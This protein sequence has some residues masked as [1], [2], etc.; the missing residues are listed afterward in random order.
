VSILNL[1]TPPETSS[2][3]RRPYQAEGLEALDWHLQHKDTTPCLVVPTGGGKSIM[4]A[5]AIQDWKRLYP[6]F[7]VCILA[8]RKELVQQNA[9]ELGA[10]WP[11]GDIGIYSA[12]LRKRDIDC[13][14]T[15]AHI[16]S[17]YEK[18]GEF[19]PFDCIIVDEAHRIPATGDG[20]YRSF[21]NGC[22][23]QNE[24][25]C[26]VG[27]TATPFRMG[28]G[29]ICHK[30]HILQE[31]C[32]EANVGTLIEQGFLC[33]LRSKIG[34]VQ[35][36]M[37]NVKRNSGGDYIVKSLANAV[38][39]PEVVEKAVR[40]AVAVI[41]A[42]NR[43][44]T[45]FFCVDLKHCKDVQNE[46]AKYG[47]HAPRVTGKT[48]AA[49]RDMIVEQFK[50]GVISAICNVNVYTEGFNAKRV[51][52]IVLLRP[53]LSP[54]LYI[55]MVGRGLRLHPEKTDCLVLDYAHCI[56]E[57][58]P[59]DCIETGEAKVE[60]CRDCGDAF[61]R[62]V[63]ICPNCGWEIP[64]QEVEK[65]EAEERKKKMHEAEASKRAI[66]GALPEIVKVDD[67]SV[68]RHCK[69]GRPD[70]IKVQY[71][72]GMSLFR[73]WICFDHGG[74]AE[75]KAR[76]WWGRRFDK[77]EAKTITVDE[78]LEDM[79]LGD[80]IN[81]VTDT[82]TVRTK[83]KHT[84]IINY[85]IWQKETESHEYAQSRIRI[86]KQRLPSTSPQ[87]QRQKAATDRMAEESYYRRSH[88]P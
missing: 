51:D 45:V 72:C 4:M 53:T 54:G 77:D 28:C 64:K 11:A 42:E 18:W 47:I 41:K 38:D 61:S 62:A 17:V 46:L 20:K 49:K 59:I 50:A 2:F 87:S 60:I 56:D 69:D 24:N 13:A 44:S 74:Y 29:P 14:I 84:E 5:W 43:K 33:K 35:P 48:S 75:Q 78:A 27:F 34:D 71:R 88:N 37:E 26:I 66:L 36:D 40:S 16:D 58:G 7:R 82:I 83:N 39:A 63:R 85:G 86:R 31:I 67:V 80:R 6:P 81:T 9:Q 73:E 57:H 30:D 12:S 21:I 1:F 3:S 55:Q 32:Y 10:L 19:P 79:L 76:A 8:H 70:S 22:K 52:C 25:L 15:F 68:H 23:T 65:R